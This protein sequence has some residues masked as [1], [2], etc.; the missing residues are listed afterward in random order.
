MNKYI[1]ITKKKYKFLN[2]IFY[3]LIIIL[4]IYS[5]SFYFNTNKNK[6]VISNSKNNYFIIPDDKKGEKINYINKKS[7]NNL[8]NH[9]NN[10]NFT[11]NIIDLKFTIQLFSDVKLENIANYLDKI[12]TPK[13]EIILEDQLHIFSINSEIGTDYFITYKNFNTKSEALSYCN[14]LSFVKRCLIINPKN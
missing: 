13:N 3:I 11:S 2:F 8:S 12:I 7:I 5:L 1:F 10:D 9:K 6:F 4:I 14:K